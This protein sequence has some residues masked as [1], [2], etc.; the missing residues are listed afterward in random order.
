MQDIK[1]QNIKKT[2]LFSSLVGALLIIAD[3]VSKYFVKLNL[4]L[5]HSRGPTTVIIPG[6]LEFKHVTND[7]FSFNYTDGAAVSVFVPA[8]VI[9]IG[10]I[11]LIT[12]KIKH[13][14]LIWATVFIISGGFGNV[15]DYFYHSHVTDFIHIMMTRRIQF[16]F[17]FNI[18]DMGVVTGVVFMIVY[19]ISESKK[20]KVI[21]NLET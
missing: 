2:Y 3:L 1:K 19:F 18:A 15:I 20:N 21:K 6:F 17:I 8:I 7:N 5:S 4:S 16:P 14:L 13:P 10:L 11:L 9:I 12:R